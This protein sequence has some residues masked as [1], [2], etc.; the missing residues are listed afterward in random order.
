M[1]LFVSE[2]SDGR[3][4]C[5]DAIRGIAACVVAFFFHYYFLADQN[6]VNFFPSFLTP[7]VKM[8]SL[9]GD[10]AV[11]LFFLISGLVFY[12][13]YRERIADCKTSAKKFTFNRFSHLYPL[14]ILLLVVN[15]VLKLKF[16]DGQ[17]ASAPT[18]WTFVQNLTLTSAWYE[19]N[20]PTIIGGAW[21]LSIEFLLYVLFF[22]FAKKVKAKNDIPI[23]LLTIFVSIAIKFAGANFLVFNEEVSR[24]LMGF[25]I[26]CL[27]WKF[28]KYI[29]TKGVKLNTIILCV[30]SVLVI[31][32]PLLHYFFADPLFTDDRTFIKSLYVILVFPS[33]LLIALRFKPINWVCSLKPFRI[34]GNLSYSI[35]LIHLT[36]IAAVPFINEN[37][38]ATISFAGRKGFLIYF[39]IV[40]ILSTAIYFLYEHPL[41]KLLR[42]KIK[43]A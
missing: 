29:C 24:G 19:S 41:Q 31:A 21:A 13:I 42:K 43:V 8:F 2:Q 12:Y 11:D 34:L 26:G 23:F 27:L 39:A 3:I 15:F 28:Y 33:I 4:Y 30:C 7:F 14:I 40:M 1:N 32:I 36:V 37:F 25:A 35:Y 17:L 22:I 38:G 5:L 6:I 10:F 16:V 9:Y 18:L 20:A